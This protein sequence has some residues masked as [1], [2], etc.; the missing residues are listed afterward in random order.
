VP[1][2]PSRQNSGGRAGGVLN[3]AE[4]NENVGRLHSVQNGENYSAQVG[5]LASAESVCQRVG[6]LSG[7]LSHE[8][9]RKA[10]PV[11]PKRTNSFKGDMRISGGDVANEE[12]GHGAMNGCSGDAP[13]VLATKPPVAAVPLTGYAAEDSCLSGKSH[14]RPTIASAA[15]TVQREPSCSPGPF[16]ANML[17]FANEN[18]GTI[19]QRS[20]GA[21]STDT[22]DDASPPVR[23]PLTNADVSTGTGVYYSWHCVEFIATLVGYSLVNLARIHLERWSSS[24]KSTGLSVGWKTN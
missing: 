12:R 6:E 17:P 22:G 19:R 23:T 4:S 2:H 20:G 10:P 13:S 7:P 11:P 15:G 3:K 8:S 9:P 16:D 21:S 1:P 24:R 14:G 5:H 18:V